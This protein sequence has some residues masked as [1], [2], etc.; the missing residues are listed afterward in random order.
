MRIND[1]ALKIPIFH[2]FYFVILQFVHFALQHVQF[3][4]L[5]FVLPLLNLAHF[6]L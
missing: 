5:L 3:V 2:A 6:K 1:N 4:R